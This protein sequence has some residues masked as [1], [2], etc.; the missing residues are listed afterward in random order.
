MFG[1]S[2]I[3]LLVKVRQDLGVAVRVKAVSASEEARAK[4]R[5]VIELAVLRRPDTSRFIRHRLA[6]AFDVDDAQ[7]AR[8]ERESLAAHGKTIIRATM[9]QRRQHRIEGRH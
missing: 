8:T 7:P 2:A 3:E 1:N 6:A 9:T 4:L 5:V